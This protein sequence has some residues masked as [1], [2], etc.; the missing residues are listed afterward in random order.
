MRPDIRA[1]LL[2]IHDAMA[3]FSW[4]RRRVSRR[5]GSY[6]QAFMLILCSVQRENDDFE[7]ILNELEEA[8]RQREEKLAFIKHRESR[9]VVLITT[10]SSIAWLAYIALWY[11]GILDYA[12]NAL[13][14]SAGY[15]EQEQGIL[16][17]AVKTLPI[18]AVPVVCA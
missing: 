3:W 14:G 13:N 18:G 10:Y 6:S 7:T 4:F 16:E 1:S 17:Q 11:F 12:T 8:I 15:E 5:P 9:G 2:F